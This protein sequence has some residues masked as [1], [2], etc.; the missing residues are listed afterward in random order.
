MR[1]FNFILVATLAVGGCDGKVDS[2]DG[3]GSETGGSVATGGAAS[4]GGA[5]ATGGF[6][7]VAGQ[8][9]HAALDCASLSEEDCEEES[10]CQVFKAYAY[11][12]SDACRAADYEGKGC[13]AVGCPTALILATDDDENTW[14]FF[15]GC[16][17]PGWSEA[18]VP[19]GTDICGAG[20]D[21]GTAN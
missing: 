17:P 5:R 8:A 15:N 10:K 3:G 20:G 12:S 21:G 7:A 19:S 13:G 18:G 6:R 4:I 11:D 1:N 16:L 9:G 14:L 2:G